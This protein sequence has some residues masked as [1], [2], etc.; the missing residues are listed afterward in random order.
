[1]YCVMNVVYGLQFVTNGS[2]PEIISE[3]IEEE[4]INGFYSGGGDSWGYFGVGLAG[5]DECD[6]YRVSD[7]QLAPTP[8]Q[9]AEYQAAW[10]ALPADLQAALIKIC[11][12]STPEVWIIPS[13]S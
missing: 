2:T 8:A 11:E 7:L 12:T 4:I 5:F 13:S 9:I 10:D 1:M 3:A 6:A